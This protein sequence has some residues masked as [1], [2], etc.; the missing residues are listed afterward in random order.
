MCKWWAPKLAFDVVHQCLLLNGH[1]AYTTEMP[2]EQRLRDVL[3]LQL[4][5]GTAQIM[6]LV[7][8]RE[9]V[10]RDAVSS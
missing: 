5:D 3:G 10:G 1:G 6:K 7:I 8:A 2:Y 4:G 9:K